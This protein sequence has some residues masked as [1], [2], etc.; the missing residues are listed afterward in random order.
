MLT[1]PG[2]MSA[3]VGEDERDRWLTIELRQLAALATVAREASFTGAADSL[4]YVESAIGRQIV[5]LERTVGRRLVER[6]G[7]RRSLSLTEAGAVLLDHFEQILAQL[8]LA[9]DEIDAV[10]RPEGQPINVGMAAI[11]GTWL[12]ATLLVE[13]LPEAGSETWR[14]LRRGSSAQLLDAVAD[15]TLDAAFVE[16]P[17][18]SGPFFALELLREPCVLVVPPGARAGGETPLRQRS[19]V[20]IDDCK[21]TEALLRRRRS[22][23]EPVAVLHT[24]ESPASA[25]PIVRSGAAA[26]VMTRRD[27]PAS[28]P[29]LATIALPGVPDRVLALAWH[30]NRDTCPQLAALRATARRAFDGAAPRRR[31]SGAEG[32]R[33]GSQ[34]GRRLSRMSPT[35]AS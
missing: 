6:S 10:T 21:A 1:R 8:R 13:I 14:D 12:P 35:G 30:R 24:A 15:G 4:G 19:L 11:F 29:P 23:G 31:Q 3:S 22:T 16:L 27:L 7:R 9:K 17:I 25:L 28:A 2:R 33:E 26:A 20:S 32:G 5:Q 18:A 34:T